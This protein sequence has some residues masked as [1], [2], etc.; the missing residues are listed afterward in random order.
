VVSATKIQKYTIDQNAFSDFITGHTSLAA[1]TVDSNGN[2]YV[3][4]A[5]K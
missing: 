5:G 4:E 3:S 2:V 1:C